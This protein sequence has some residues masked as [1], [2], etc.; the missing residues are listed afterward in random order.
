MKHELSID[1]SVNVLVVNFILRCDC[2][3]TTDFLL[4]LVL[5]FV[6]NRRKAPPFS[7]ITN[8]L[9]LNLTISGLSSAPA[10]F[11]AS[12]FFKFVYLACSVLN[13]NDIFENASTMIF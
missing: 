8:L 11:L 7:K 12:E 5:I 2:D 10:L 9:L 13:S 1:S 4:I 6:A 3:I